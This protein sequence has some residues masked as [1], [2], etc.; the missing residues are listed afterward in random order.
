[1]KRE[2]WVQKPMYAPHGGPMP[3]YKYTHTVYNRIHVCSPHGITVEIDFHPN[4]CVISIP[5]PLQNVH[6]LYCHC[7][8]NLSSS[9]TD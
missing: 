7:R 4:V 5:S 8:V 1:M 2:H 9:L 6:V 3:S